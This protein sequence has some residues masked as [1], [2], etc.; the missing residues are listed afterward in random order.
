MNYQSMTKAQLIQYIEDLERTS[1]E[2]INEL[3]EQTFGKKWEYFQKEV[4][5]LG[6]DII[7]LVQFVYELGVQAGRHFHGA[8]GTLKQQVEVVKTDQSFDY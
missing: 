4:Q 1:M 3:E 6:Q 7:K 2:L 8:V 5:L